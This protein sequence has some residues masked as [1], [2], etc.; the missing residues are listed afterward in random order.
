M[1]LRRMIEHVKMQ[2][3]TAVAIDF[4]I[5]VIG[6]G[7]ALAAEQWISG[8]QERAD[9]KVAEQSL[10]SDVFSNYMFAKERLALATC[11][12][13]GLQKIADDLQREE[14]MPLSD[15]GDESLRRFVFPAVF[16]TPTRPWG[17]RLWDA[18]LGRGALSG[19]EIEKRNELGL[20][21][22][23]AQ[24]IADLQSNMLIDSARLK[25]LTLL[26]SMTDDAR[27]RY[28]DTVMQIDNGG[29]VIEMISEQMVEIAHSMI[30]EH[31]YSNA[32]HSEMQRSLQQLS[33][34]G[35]RAYGDCYQPIQSP[36]FDLE[37]TN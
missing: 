32:E 15:R 10:Q 8:S 26:D 3:W 28:L 7:I 18:E 31:E 24:T 22:H 25:S 2:N 29:T 27:A 23:G 4:V 34:I 6:V 16:S 17:S 20:F 21:F 13:E 35:Q 1:L 14:W 11:R 36:L 33:R 30:S 9:F 5:V 19:L 37:A 12:K